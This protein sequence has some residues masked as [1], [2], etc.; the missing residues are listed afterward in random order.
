LR[1]RYSGNSLSIRA[2][3]AS[4][5]GSKSLAMSGGAPS[6]SAACLKL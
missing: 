1:A 3:A 5:Y 4:A 2:W 6:S